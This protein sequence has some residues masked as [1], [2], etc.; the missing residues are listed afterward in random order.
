MTRARDRLGNETAQ[1]L[2]LSAANS[3]GSWM[4]GKGETVPCESLLKAWQ[5]GRVRWPRA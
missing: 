2:A 5:E 4:V 3:P 1:E